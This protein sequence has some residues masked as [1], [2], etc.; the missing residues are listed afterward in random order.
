MVVL[1]TSAVIEILRGSKKGAQI[2]DAIGHE[3]VFITAFTVHEIMMGVKETEIYKTQG[4]L[5][6]VEILVFDFSSAM[7]SSQIE[8]GLIKKGKKIEESD[9]F[10][11]GICL[12]NNL[13]LIT[14]DNDFIEIK[15]LDVKVF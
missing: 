6:S 15:E 13:G 5:S 12:A 4:F 11:A 7:A 2:E 10:I 9:I 1:D 3:K 8:R 14:L